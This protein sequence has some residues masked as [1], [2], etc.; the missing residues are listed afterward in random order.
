MNIGIIG[1]GSIGASLAGDWRQAGH[2]VVG[3][4][5]RQS[6]CDLA[7]ERGFIDRG[8][9]DLEILTGLDV[10]VI[11]TPIADILPTLARSI[12][13]IDP[14]TIVTDVGSVKEAIVAP[15]TKIRSNFIGGHPMAGKAT[16][17][18]E[19]AELGMFAGKP[20]VLTP[21]ESTP[22]RAIDLLTQLAI[23]LNARLDLAAPTEHDRAVAWISHLPVMVSAS[24]I[25]A[26][27]QEQDRSV[28]GLAQKLASSGFK[29]TSRVGGGNPELGM[30]MARYNQAAILDA[31]AI[32]R[33]Q[34]DRLE[35][36]IST[37][38]WAEV[39]AILE[40]TQNARPDFVKVPI[41]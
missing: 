23:D 17:G 22:Q 13:V 27:T 18:I 5:R 20:Y 25:D 26:C 35:Q 30:M 19:A 29:D 33:Q 40:H 31:I 12:A 32:Y 39:T 7:I 37:N 14:E 1:L 3:V 15:A 16:S 8:S 11:C 24:L 4:S 34:L 21:L 6:T 10:L 28:L 41:P 2:V 36:A 38:Q 9:T